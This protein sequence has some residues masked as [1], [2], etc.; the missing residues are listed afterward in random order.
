MSDDTTQRDIGRLEARM[1]GLEDWARAQSKQ[2]DEMSK[3]LASI[4]NDLSAAKGASRAVI[5][6]AMMFGGAVTWLASHFADRVFK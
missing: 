2:L 5:G 4:N 3:T 1:E 6:M